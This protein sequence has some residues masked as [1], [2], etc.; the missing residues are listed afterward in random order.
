MARSPRRTRN[1]RQRTWSII[2]YLSLILCA[3]F[4]IT[5]ARADSTTRS[6]TDSS[7]DISGP[8]IGIDLGTTY[9]CV[10]VY[11]TYPFSPPLHSNLRGNK[12]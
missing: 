10:S 9:S 3:G 2:F 11:V 6:S 7:T 12:K 8:V 4:I 1:S 5:H